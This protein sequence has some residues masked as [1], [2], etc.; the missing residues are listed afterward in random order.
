MQI[1]SFGTAQIAYGKTETIDKESLVT[2]A[3]REDKPNTAAI[4]LPTNDKG[5]TRIVD[6][7]EVKE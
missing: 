5:V 7:R 6:L 4:M 1:G 3:E 2:I